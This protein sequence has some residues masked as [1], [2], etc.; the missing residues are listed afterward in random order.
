MQMAHRLQVVEPQVENLETEE[1]QWPKVTKQLWHRNE[2]QLLRGQRRME[3]GLEGL[4]L[5]GL[6]P[7]PAGLRSG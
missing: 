1:A 2:P 3:S 7:H 6:V 4:R 5:N